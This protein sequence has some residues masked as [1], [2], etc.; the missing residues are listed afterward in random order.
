LKIE[1]FNCK[2]PSFKFTGVTGCTNNDGEDGL[3]RSCERVLQGVKEE[4]NI[5]HTIKQKKV[6]WIGYRLRRNC[7]L[8]HV[9][10]GKTEGTGGWGRRRT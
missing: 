3:D 1:F 10:E 7:L 8:K 2:W 5:V 9:L 4:R 6:N